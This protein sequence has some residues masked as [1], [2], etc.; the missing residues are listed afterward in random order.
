ME[1]HE[2]H[3][4]ETRYLGGGVSLICNMKP[5]ELS[6]MTQILGDGTRASV[7]L[8]NHTMTVILMVLSGSKSDHPTLQWK[9]PRKSTNFLKNNIFLQLIPKYVLNHNH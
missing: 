8:I 5:S 6:K 3:E 7:S 4:L 1:I 2:A 9:I